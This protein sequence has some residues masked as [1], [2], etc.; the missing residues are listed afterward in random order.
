M[1]KDSFER[2]K[3]YDIAAELLLETAD[4][5]PPAQRGRPPKWSLHF[6]PKQWHK[7]HRDQTMEYCQLSQARLLKY[8][9]ELKD[10]REWLRKKA[11]SLEAPSA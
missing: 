5:Q 2:V 10:I 3:Q 7:D 1:D 9:E 8:G 4:I 6:E 11:L